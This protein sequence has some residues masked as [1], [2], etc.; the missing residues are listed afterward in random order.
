MTPL[1]R[2]RPAAIMVCMSVTYYNMLILEHRA[3]IQE[4]M[5]AMEELLIACIVACLPP[6]VLES[7]DEHPLKQ[8]KVEML[9][10]ME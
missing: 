7:S 9:D 10:K 2:R 5:C 3:E 6:D 8:E 1:H 4:Q